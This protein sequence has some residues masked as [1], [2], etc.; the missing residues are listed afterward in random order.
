MTACRCTGVTVI[1]WCAWLCIRA[2]WVFNQSKPSFY[3]RQ[4]NG[5]VHLTHVTSFSFICVVFSH[6]DLL[7]L[8]RWQHSS[9]EAQPDEE[10][11]LLGK[12]SHSLHRSSEFTLIHLFWRY[13]MIMIMIKICQQFWSICVSCPVA[14][15]LS[16]FR[17]GRASGAAPGWTAHSPQHGDSQMS[18]ERLW[19]FFSH[20]AGSSAGNEMIPVISIH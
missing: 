14:Q 8:L 6:A 18:L 19:C 16:Y 20:T 7:R 12:D 2:W 15:L 1:W 13:L 3:H 10:P 11:P 4:L 5:D 17:H 9:S